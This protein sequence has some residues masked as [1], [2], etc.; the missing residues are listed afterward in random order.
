MRRAA[1]DTMIGSR[2]PFRW[3]WCV[4]AVLAI[5]AGACSRIVDLTLPASSQP[6]R[7]AEVY[8]QW[9]SLM[10]GCSGVTG[11][12]SAITWFVVPD[13][14]TID[15]EGTEVAAYWSLAGNRIVLTGP[16]VLDGGVVR[17]EMLHALLRTGGH[18][19]DQFLGK[20]A[21]LVSC[22]GKC[23]EDGG[24]APPA[25]PAS[26]NTFVDGMEVTSELG[27]VSLVH[28]AEGDVL[29]VTVIVRN[30]ATY[31]V[32]VQFPLQAGSPLAD[33]FLYDLRGPTSGVTGGLPLNDP[34]RWD[35]APWESKR[36]VFD[37]ASR[38][39]FGSDRFPPGAYQVRGAY[40]G[41][42]SAYV[43]FVVP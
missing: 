8:A 40:G 6:L 38:V 34:T 27:P 37:F 14:Q 3:W 13:A 5:P 24:P 15:L 9:W 1:R 36:Q 25:D 33:G 28:T 12:L 29:S 11:D 42:W 31:P 4:I 23:V 22:P 19:R 10:E 18:P 32:V 41:K 43:P 21:G 2:N 17:H 30:P 35:F 39:V 20:C 26:V 7:P 16:R